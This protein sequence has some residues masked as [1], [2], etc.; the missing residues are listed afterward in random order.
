[1]DETLNFKDKCKTS[2]IKVDV[3]R[4]L[5]VHGILM[6]TA[7]DIKTPNISTE[8]GKFFHLMLS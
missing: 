4:N 6:P 8:L 1:M 3:I 7:G 5:N 2:D